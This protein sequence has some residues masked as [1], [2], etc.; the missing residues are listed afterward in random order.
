MCFFR[1]FPKQLFFFSYFDQIIFEEDILETKN[2]HLCSMFVNLRAGILLIPGSLDLQ[3]TKIHKKTLDDWIVGR[4]G[5]FF[6]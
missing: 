5:V 1:S 3:H 2:V 6:C 4:T